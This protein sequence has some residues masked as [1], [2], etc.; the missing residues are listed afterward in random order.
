MATTTTQND[1]S[2]SMPLA[3]TGPY[4]LEFTNI[5]AGFSLGVQGADSGG[6]VQVI[7]DGGGTFG[8]ALS[9]NSSATASTPIEIGDRVWIDTNNDGSQ[10]PDEPGL[11]SVQVQ[12]VDMAFL[13]L[14]HVKADAFAV[15]CNLDFV[16]RRG[17]LIHLG[18][19]VIGLVDIGVG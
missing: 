7:P 14:A 12:L 10:D 5:P 11:G 19:A 3:G 6:Q 17:G 15:R 18:A 8:V 1:G 2:Y 9:K 16:D 13:E 4:R